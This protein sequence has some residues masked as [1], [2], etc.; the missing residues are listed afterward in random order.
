MYMYMLR[1]CTGNY[2]GFPLICARLICVFQDNISLLKSICSTIHFWMKEL[3][4]YLQI[5]YADVKFVNMPKRR[6][7]RIY[8]HLLSLTRKKYGRSTSDKQVLSVS[9][10]QSPECIKI[11][12]DCF[13]ATER[14][15]LFSCWLRNL[16]IYCT[17]RYHQQQRKIL[18]HLYC[19]R[20]LKMH[21]LLMTFF[22]SH[23]TKVNISD[24]HYFHQPVLTDK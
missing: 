3:F 12:A 11:C 21:N 22:L 16:R 7:R 13:A 8:H 6:H 17:S 14:G 24:S 4:V 9:A 20:K 19:R 1:T 10:K 18:E 23:Q 15:K 2:S 5:L